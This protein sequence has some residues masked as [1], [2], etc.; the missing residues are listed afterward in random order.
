MKHRIQVL[1]QQAD[2]R[3][4]DPTAF[5]SSLPPHSKAS[6]GLICQTQ[7]LAGIARLP[8]P[9]LPWAGFGKDF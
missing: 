1:Q 6:G 7:P 3:K 8:T 5:L 4:Q 9:L 2:E